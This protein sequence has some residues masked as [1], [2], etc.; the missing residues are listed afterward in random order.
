MT[1]IV[2]ADSPFADAEVV[3]DSWTK[4]SFSGIRALPQSLEPGFRQQALYDTVKRGITYLSWIS[5]RTQHESGS[6]Q[7]FCTNPQQ[8]TKSMRRAPD[9]THR[10]SNVYS[11][12]GGLSL[13]DCRQAGAAAARSAR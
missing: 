9:I 10:D 1:L 6:L 3:T 2:L 5:V 12:A 13:D 4:Q 11:P 7:R 8:V